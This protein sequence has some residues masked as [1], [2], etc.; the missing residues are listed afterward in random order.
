MLSAF[1]CVASAASYLVELAFELCERREE[2]VCRAVALAH[3]NG[4]AELT[5]H[6]ADREPARRRTASCAHSGG[7][8]CQ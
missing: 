8:Q 2:G 5:A 3:S 6:L 1:A 4:G 7:G